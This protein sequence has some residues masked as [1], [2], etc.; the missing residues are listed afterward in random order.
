VLE[1]ER[2]IGHAGRLAGRVAERHGDGGARRT[3]RKLA[4]SVGSAAHR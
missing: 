1:L 3:E 2:Q 4:P